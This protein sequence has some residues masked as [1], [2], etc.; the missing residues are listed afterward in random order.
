MINSNIVDILKEKG[1]IFEEGLNV[2]EIDAIQRLY[3]IKFPPDLKEL[4]MR[5]L[6]VSDKFVNWRDLSQENINTIN[7][8]LNWPIDGIIYDIENNEFWYS[9]WGHRPDNLLEAT[10]IC[11]VEME[12]VPRLIPIYAHRYLPSEPEEIGNPI[13]SINQTDIIY[14]GEDL[15]SYLLIEFKIK[16]VE[17][18]NYKSIKKIRFWSDLQS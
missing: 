16:E 11:R 14:Y 1:V 3:Q 15:L 9:S 4:L 5:A 8:K 17:D 2:Q 12:K 10:M 6:P 7:E 18:M 13:F